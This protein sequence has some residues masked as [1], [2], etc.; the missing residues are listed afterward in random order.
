MLLLLIT[1]A[2]VAALAPLGRD[3]LRGTVP[4]RAAVAGAAAGLAAVLFALTWPPP[5]LPPDSRPLVE[6]AA[7]YVG[8][9]ACRA[10]HPDQ[11]ASWH[12][13][14]HRTMTQVATRGSVAAEFRRVELSWA[15]EP[16]IYEWR[17][18]ELWVDFLPAPG[19][20]RR[21]VRPIEQLTGSHHFQVFWYG[22]GRGRELAPAPFVY[23]IDTQR[24]LPFAAAF[25]IPPEQDGLPHA[26][27]WNQNCHMCHATG[28]RPRLTA[29]GA[30]TRVSEL[31]IACEACH[32]PGA[33]HAASNRDPR[34]RYALHDGDAA[35]DTIVE[36][37][38]LPPARSAQVCGQCHSVSILRRSHSADWSERGLPYRPGDDLHATRLVIMPED[39]QA[40]EL[41][42]KLAEQPHFFRDTFW[43]DGAVR[44]A[45]REYN[46]LLRSP[47]FTQA[48]A[49][50]QLDCTDC[51]Q[52]HLAPDD[53]RSLADWTED[54]LAPG[55]R[56][57]RACT[58]C[59]T[60][61]TAP[62]ARRAHTHHADG[63]PGSACMNC[64][65]SYTTY[66][67]LKATRSHTIGS[68]SVAQELATGRPNACNQCHLDRTLAWTNDHL[69]QWYGIEPA[70]L[71]ADQAG[72]AASIRWLLT[73]DAGIRALAA[74][75]M[76][77]PAA[78]QASGRDWQAPYLGQLL[79]DPYRAVRY[80]AE[81]SLHTLPG[82]AVPAGYD[83]LAQGSGPA[84]AAAA[85]R[86]RWQQA[87]APGAAARAE[88][89]M[90]AQGLVLAEFQRLLARR[91]DRPVFLA[92]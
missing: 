60:Q 20:A 56:D 44:V 37:T 29:T 77:W 7:G 47:C 75:S 35:D 16:A 3:F 85:V 6:P 42:R 78:Q 31:G 52:L 8:S 1:L 39:A 91:D 10:C 73:G 9:A 32:G 63:S 66:G 57:D 18:E 33:E 84:Q 21:V 36:P 61:F 40:P 82:V 48:P 90:D 74:W 62:E 26:G 71:D 15:G 45:G 11:H 49:D 19:A 25:V 68:P 30:D 55:M 89:L 23:R 79:A 43:S 13:S 27:T 2:A 59:H 38:R 72:V 24:W 34:R 67:L 17:G 69:Q 4:G 88:L 41:Q 12:A 65:M 92:E 5:P 81:Q 54:Q 58:Q 46:G 83:S 28:V 80:L 76:G 22:T 64:H 53:E 51:H 14:F 50:A 86:D 70:A 87:R